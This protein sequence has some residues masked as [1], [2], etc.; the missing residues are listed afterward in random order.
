[1]RRLIDVLRDELNT[2]GYGSTPIIISELMGAVKGHETKLVDSPEDE[3]ISSH[4]QAGTDLRAKT[5]VGSMLARLAVAR[6]RNERAALTGSPDKP[7]SA[8]AFILRSLKHQDEVEELRRIYENG[9]VA[10]AAYAP[11]SFR[12]KAM[13][14]AISKTRPGLIE[15]QVRNISNKLVQRDEAEEGEDLGQ[16]VVYRGFCDLALDC[17]VRRTVRGERRFI[18]SIGRNG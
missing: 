10:I 2:V 8:H 12:E 13:S 6:I 4:M 16:S 18:A 3:R 17:S 14:Q 9:F 15:D 7:A 5:K 1:M 11:R